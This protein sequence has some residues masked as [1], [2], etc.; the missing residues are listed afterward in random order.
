MIHLHYIIYTEAFYNR[1]CGDDRIQMIIVRGGEIKGF[2]Y[3][4][5][6]RLSS[7]S[8]LQFSMFAYLQIMCC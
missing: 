1:F 4:V 3:R 5:A 6:T 7:R 2:Y 8:A